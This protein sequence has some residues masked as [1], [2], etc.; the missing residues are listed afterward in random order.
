MGEGGEKACEMS[1]SYLVYNLFM[2]LVLPLATPLIFWRWRHRILARRKKRWGE[3]FGFWPQEVHGAL[4][5]PSRWVWLHVASVGEWKAVRGLLVAMR[6][7]WTDW[8]ILVSAVTPEAV[9]LAREEPLADIVIAA[10]LDLF[11]IPRRAIDLVRPNLFL[12]VE[13]EL[14]PNIIRAAHRA[15]ARTVLVNGRV[16]ERS[17]RHLRWIRPLL[18]ALWDE[19]DV[20]AVRHAQDAERYRALGVP[21]HKLRITG[22]LKWD[23]V[24]PAPHPPRAR[25]LEMLGLSDDRAVV[26]AGSTREGEE[27]VLLP[28]FENVRARR[29]NVRFILAPRHPERAHELESLLRSYQV[30]FQ[31]KSA[32]NGKNEW[33]G[34]LVWDSLGDLG[35]AY[36]VADVA[37]IGG[38][39]VPKGGQNPIEP[40][41][42]GIPVIFG[43]SMENF[44]GVT[45]MLRETGAAFQ[46]SGDR[47]G[48]TL[49]H[50]LTDSSLRVQAGARARQVVEAERGG[51]ERTIALLEDL[52]RA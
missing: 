50:L 44:P 28:A 21:D 7:R 5:K 45:E 51:T 42:M 52:I 29:P 38:S 4:S 9:G 47:L 49:L 36:G 15:G 6:A 23:N 34:Y 48:E 22:N 3:R 43:P 32:L 8:G 40:A 35:D 24:S 14:W 39:F 25:A 1:I 46:V 26:V 11:G 2:L 13:T 37:V 17:F 10:P 33:E 31:R 18:K 16:S 27:A 12:T 19:L 30:P 41:G 20:M